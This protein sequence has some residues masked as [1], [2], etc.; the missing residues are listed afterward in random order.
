MA[1][2][3]A[4]TEALLG[5]Y[6]I[7][8]I[9]DEQ[10]EYCGKRLADAGAD[11]IKIEP[12]QGNSTRRKGP[13]FHDQFG[14]ETSLHFLHFNTNKRSVTLNLECRDGQELF[15]KLVLE[16]DAVVESM[17][18]GYLSSLGLDYK[19]LSALNPALVMA[20]VT[21]FGQTGP[22]KDYQATDIVNMA[23]GG[24]MQSCGEPDGMPTRGGC[25]QSYQVG[26]ENA[27]VG[28]MAALYH[29]AMTGKGQYVDTSI[30]ECLLTYGHE[31]V[32]AQSWAVHKHIVVRAGARTRWGFPYGLF[33]CKD[34]FALI[35]CV[36]APEW[37]HLAAWIHEVT[38][39]SEVLDDMFKGI[40]FDRAPYVDLLTGYLIDFSQRLTKKELFLEGQR[41]KI[42][43]MPVQSIEDVMNCPQLHE[44]G[45]FKN[46][47]HP[48]VG[49]VQDIGS[50]DRCGEGSLEEWKAAPLLGEHNEEIYC[51]EMGYSRDDLAILRNNG[52]I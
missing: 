45:F 33:P 44:S 8:E 11:V 30:Q 47:S 39:C 52:V 38:G 50:P 13:F 40:L 6:R 5:C 42:T 4:K 34:G 18:V 22:H 28:I 36:Q 48:V 3:K 17:P 43:I 35:A 12:P 29:S 32:P 49:E 19:F 27:A 24:F 46:L 2:S 9:A 20:S 15:K 14:L 37:D 25:E 51:S 1:R 10:G 7:L 26:S 16:A 21:P 23:M 31:A 41:R